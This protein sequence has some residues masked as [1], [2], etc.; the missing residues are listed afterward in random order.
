MNMFLT[1]KS[2]ASC[3]KKCGKDLHI[4]ICLVQWMF[5]VVHSGIDCS[6]ELLCFFDPLRN[7]CKLIALKCEF[8]GNLKHKLN[9]L[10]G[11]RDPDNNHLAKRSHYS[12]CPM[13]CQCFRNQTLIIVRHWEDHCTVRILGIGAELGV[14]NEGGGED[15]DRAMRCR[16][17]GRQQPISYIHASRHMRLTRYQSQTIKEFNTCLISPVCP[18]NGW[19]ISQNSH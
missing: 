5:L 2:Y 1:T 11:C 16:L 4:I 13:L 14:E 12:G 10:E 18:I 3:N 15:N 7:A 8:D 17:F 9:S 6:E 19:V